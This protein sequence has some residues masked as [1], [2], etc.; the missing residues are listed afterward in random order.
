MAVEIA[1]LVSFNF[2]EDATGTFVGGVSHDDAAFRALYNKPGWTLKTFPPDYDYPDPT[3][4]T[5]DP[6]TGELTPRPPLPPTPFNPSG[7][8]AEMSAEAAQI[9]E[10][11][12]SSSALGTPHWYPLGLIDQINILSGALISCRDQDGVWAKIKHTPEQLGVLKDAMVG[13]IDTV[14]MNFESARSEALTATSKA[15]ADSIQ[16]TLDGKISASVGPVVS[17]DTIAREKV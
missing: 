10:K 5:M 15:E 2:I 7:K 17:A 9:I 11:G 12:F 3:T 1:P 14:R 8:I 6:S 13:K 4:H 16:L